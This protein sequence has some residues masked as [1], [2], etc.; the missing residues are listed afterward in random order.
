MGDSMIQEYGKLV[1]FFFDEHVGS[2][3]FEDEI[4]AFVMRFLYQIDPVVPDAGP[5]GFPG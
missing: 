5:L 3:G 1:L 4:A 2:R